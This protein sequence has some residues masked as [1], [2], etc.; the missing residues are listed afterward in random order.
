LFPAIYASRDTLP[1]D[2]TMLPRIARPVFFAALALTATVLADDA[3]RRK[4]E[5]GALTVTA[6]K[7]WTPKEPAFKGLIMYEFAAPAAKEDKVDGRMTVSSAGGSVEDNIRRWQG[8]FK[9]EDGG[10]TKK[11]AKTEKLK[12]AGHTVH[13]VDL[14]GTYNDQRPG[15]RPAKDYRM[16]AAIIETKEANF[17]IKFYGP[18]RTISQHEKAFR[19]MIEEAKA[20]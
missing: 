12:V 17:F 11:R 20:E 14:S 9:Q 6:P 16:L 5:L 2:E 4:M 8:Q 1:E 3:D 19:E 10:D 13:W 15:S 18:R 7:D